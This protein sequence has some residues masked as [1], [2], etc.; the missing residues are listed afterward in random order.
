MILKWKWQN[1]TELEAFCY[2]AFCWEK[3]NPA[4]KFNNSTLGFLSTLRAYWFVNWCLF[5][6]NIEHFS[7]WQDKHKSNVRS[8]FSFVSCHRICWHCHRSFQS[9]KREQVR[10]AQD[11]HHSPGNR[12]RKIRQNERGVV[13]LLVILALGAQAGGLEVGNQSRLHIQMLFQRYNKI[14]SY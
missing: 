5:V 11:C 3:K 14:G 8:N 6:F 4:A 7:K 13:H 10:A 9:V 12:R 1:K 2:L